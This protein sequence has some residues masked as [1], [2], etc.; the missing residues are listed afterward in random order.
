MAHIDQQQRER[1]RAALVALNM[2]PVDGPQR[3]A[4]HLYRESKRARGDERYIYA[5]ATGKKKP[6]PDWVSGMLKAAL[7]PPG[8]GEL[9]AARAEIQ[10]AAESG[11]AVVTWPEDAYP[12]NLQES[13]SPPPVL[14]VKG[15][16]LP[17]DRA[18]IAIVGARRS[19][20]AY[21]E[22]AADLA[23]GLAKAGFTVVSGLAR[24]IDRAAHEG[25][26]EA[27]GRTL[28]VLGSGVDVIYPPEHGRLAEAIVAQGALL[29]CFPLGARPVGYH[30]P[31]R[32]WVIAGL[33]LGVV[34]IQAAAGS[35]A[36][37]TANSAVAMGRE[38]MAVPGPLSHPLHRGSNGLIR[39]GARLV[40]SAGDVVK[41]ME[42]ALANAGIRTAAA[43]SVPKQF[44]GPGLPASAGA[45]RWDQP[46][47][48]E[49]S[50][51][52][53]ILGA[54]IDGPLAAAELAARCGVDVGEAQAVLTRLEIDGRVARV[55]GGRWRLCERR[56]S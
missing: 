11:V 16:L 46:P 54:L 15:K 22:L 19:T 1:L 45:R 20:R 24:G 17:E 3:A 12:V 10:R 14:Y 28:A 47:I 36:L 8:D 30:F 39:D 48:A 9:A 56:W 27:G 4:A 42:T 43:L 5:R 53:A 44:P 50:A 34:V 7:A 23:Y 13:V 35:G 40:M 31:A 18:A 37:I 26:L 25:A 55:E 41:A 29:S 6:V 52:Q 51:D 21:Q 32:N 33:S 2:R 49:W 38:V